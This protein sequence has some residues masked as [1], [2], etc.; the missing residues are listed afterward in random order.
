MSGIGLDYT[1]ESLDGLLDANPA[2]WP[3]SEGYGQ[4]GPIRLAE[5]LQLP[6]ITDMLLQRGWGEADIRKLLGGN[7]L[8]V[9]RRGVEVEARRREK[10]G[11]PKNG[12]PQSKEEANGARW[13]CARPV[14]S[15]VGQWRDGIRVRWCR[16]SPATKNAL[17]FAAAKAILSR[18][19]A[20]NPPSTAKAWPVVQAAPSEAR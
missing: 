5:P 13:E 19:R 11:P 14:G 16:R 10:G 12:G 1:P 4:G 2:F 6:E 17:F 3:A 15:A 7:F 20:V 8:R 9:A 18:Q